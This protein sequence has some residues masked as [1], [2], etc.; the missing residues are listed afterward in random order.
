MLF[1]SICGFIFFLS[2]NVALNFIL[3]LIGTKIMCLYARRKDW[4]GSLKPAFIVNLLWFVIDLSLCIYYLFFVEHLYLSVVSVVL[5]DSL[6]LCYLFTVGGSLLVDVIRIIII[7]IIIHFILGTILVMKLYKK[8]VG[9]SLISVIVVSVI[10]FL[11]GFVIGLIFG[12]ILSI[13]ACIFMD[14]IF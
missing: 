11:I 2:A 1:T 10:M 6:G 9:E 3:L 14:Y 7:R 13:L 5:L 4:G 12:L 8:K